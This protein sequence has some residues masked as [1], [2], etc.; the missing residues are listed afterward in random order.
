MQNLKDINHFNRFSV[1]IRY[2]RQL[3]SS[4][5]APSTSCFWTQ[6]QDKSTNEKRPQRWVNGE[7]GVV[8]LKMASCWSSTI[9]IDGIWS[10]GVHLWLP[11]IMID[12]FLTVPGRTNWCLAVL[13]TFSFLLL[14]CRILFVYSGTISAPSYS[15]LRTISMAL[16]ETMN[17]TN[18]DVLRS[19]IVPGR[20]IT[21]RW[22]SFIAVRPWWMG[23]ETIDFVVI[24]PRFIWN[25][26]LEQSTIHSKSCYHVTIKSILCRLRISFW[27][28]FWLRWQLCITF[29]PILWVCFDS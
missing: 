4:V 16:W 3:V 18:P 6:K 21:A 9:I 20:N 11:C 2:C 7:L 8:Y 10:V 23:D 15:I 22:G 19:C 14:F 26:C 29:D 25:S 12:N 27:V 13:R 1:N 5:S 28:D 17:S 24:H